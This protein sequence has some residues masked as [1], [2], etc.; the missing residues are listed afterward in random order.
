MD[1][2]FFFILFDSA[3]L[4]NF[5]NFLEPSVS[6]S[7]AKEKQKKFKNKTTVYWKLIEVQVHT[8]AAKAY[9]ANRVTLTPWTSK[10]NAGADQLEKR[11]TNCSI[12][13]SLKENREESFISWLRADVLRRR[14]FAIARELMSP[15]W[16]SRSG[17]SQ[18]HGC[19]RDNS[20]RFITLWK[21]IPRIG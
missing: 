13:N 10:V 21:N 2:S 9:S 11:T 18:S 3:S 8:S 7:L 5:C 15:K 19:N 14:F 6:L 17:S 16:R 12:V 1:I 4:M 20:L